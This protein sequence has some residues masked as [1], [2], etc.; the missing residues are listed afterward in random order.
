MQF[1]ED[2]R[3]SNRQHQALHAERISC[4]PEQQRFLKMRAQ[5]HAYVEDARMRE[6]PPI[7]RVVAQQELT[8]ELRRD[9]HHLAPKPAETESLHD[10]RMEQR[11]AFMASRKLR[12]DDA[13][14][15][16]NRSMDTLDDECLFSSQEAN[17]K[18]KEYIAKID[19]QAT[20]LLSSLEN[21]IANSDELT[22]DQI[23]RI[24]VEL[25]RMM[26]SR[27]I[28]VG[29][30]QN[31]LEDTENFR[32]RE[33]TS[34]LLALVESLRHAGHVSLEETEG[35][36]EIKTAKFNTLLQERLKEIRALAADLMITTLEAS[37]EYKK[38]WHA[39]LTLWRTKQQGSPEEQE[40][41][42]DVTSP[43]Q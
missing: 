14:E 38:R 2:F 31:K 26:E 15:I 33:T 36:V 41:E 34:L 3:V 39:G 18:I 11:D 43:P 35:M 7:S 21:D 29:D 9:A 20:D 12:H 40:G 22:E 19:A 1:V 4:A 17:K 25:E 6:L 28:R 23:Q 8:C 27:K 24:R 32:K 42:L 30:F 37:K 10:K 13:C 16:F 5:Q